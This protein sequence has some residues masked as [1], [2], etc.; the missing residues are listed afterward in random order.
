MRG[1]RRSGFAW[2]SMM[3]LLF[4]MF[5]SLM[6]LGALI[7]LKLGQS[8]GTDQRPFQAL[9]IEVTTA[10]VALSEA[11]QRMHLGFLLFTT[12]VKSKPPACIFSAATQAPQDCFPGIEPTKPYKRLTEF[13]TAALSSVNGSASILSASLLININTPPDAT[14]Y[15]AIKPVLADIAALLD[16]NTEVDAGK[17]SVVVRLSAKTMAGVWEPPPFTITVKELLKSAKE[18]PLIGAALFSA[19]AKMCV[20]RKAGSK[21]D[22]ISIEGGRIVFSL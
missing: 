10:D 3:D 19:N 13:A 6:L 8:S 1:K 5:G 7:S 4:G 2:V 21:C 11:L 22:E 18:A 15:I 12:N 20:M 16:T 9:T 17:S 14:T